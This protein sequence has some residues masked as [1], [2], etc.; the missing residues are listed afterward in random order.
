MTSRRLQATIAKF[1]EKKMNNGKQISQ[2]NGIPPG[3]A[4]VTVFAHP[5]LQGPGNPNGV[6]VMTNF[7]QG[8]KKASLAV[9][10][11]LSEGIHRWSEH[12][13]M[14]LTGQVAPNIVM[15]DGTPA[16]L[17]QEEKKKRPIIV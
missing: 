13:Q 10:S 9:F 2:P 4:F 17:P 6:A 15:P 3:S 12:F 7:P 16:P 11:L 1:K 8:N 14:Q 5:S